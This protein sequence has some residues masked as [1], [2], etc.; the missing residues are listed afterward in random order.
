MAAYRYDINRILSLPITI[1][2]QQAEWDMILVMARNSNFLT[3]L[4]TNLKT[5]MRHETHRKSVKEKKQKSEQHSHSTVQKSENLPT[6]LDKL[7]YT[8][9]SDAQTQYN[10]V[11]NLRSP[12]KIVNMIGVE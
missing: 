1:E 2:R 5:K 4:I 6:F 12:T 7:T 8:S 3:K 11:Q 10:N 9:H